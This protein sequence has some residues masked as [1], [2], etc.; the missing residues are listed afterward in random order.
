MKTQQKNKSIKADEKSVLL[1]ESTMLLSLQGLGQ[2]LDEASPRNLC[3]TFIVIFLC[4][5]F[6]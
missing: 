3:I 6:V 2:I 5:R 1:K 4:L